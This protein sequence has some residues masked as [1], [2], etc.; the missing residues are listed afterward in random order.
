M[1]SPSGEAGRGD[2]EGPLHRVTIGERFAVGVYEVTLEEFARFV[3]EMGGTGGDPCEEIDD[4][5]VL[6]DMRSYLSWRNPGFPQGEGHPV[7][8]VSWKDA[9]AY[10]DWL[11]GETGAEYRLLSESE[12]E[13]VARGGTEMSRYWGDSEGGQCRHANGTDR[14]AAYRYSILTRHDMV[15]VASCDDGYVNTSP[16]GNFEAN[17][18][19][20]H[21]V[22]GNVAEWVEDC[23][24]DSYRGAPL[25]G[26]AW[27]SS[28]DCVAR[29]LRGGSWSVY[30]FNS[31]WA[32][33]LRSADRSRRGPGHRASYIGFR[34][35]RTLD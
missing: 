27:T 5:G 29:A 2:T 35:A 1:G 9:R 3:S 15:R 4:T 23:W 10:V 17:G 14:S 33:Y 32:G 28:G 7:V 19:G 34:V 24:H 12:W 21:D 30:P 26:S 31:G 22:L 18:Y 20:L 8:C 25:D 11:S 13:W 16:V 6:T